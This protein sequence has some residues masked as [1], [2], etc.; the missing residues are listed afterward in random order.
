[1][2]ILFMCVAN[3]AR[4]QIAEGLANKIFANSAEIQSAGSAPSGRVHEDARLVM[5]E[6]G[7]DMSNHTSKSVSELSGAFLEG[8]DFVISLCAEEVCPVILTKANRLR[9]SLPDPAGTDKSA[10][11]RILAFRAVRD[12]INKRLIEFKEEVLG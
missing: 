1:M 5:S 12:E 11:E 2:K 8:L 6:V 9:W 3:S 7:I 4:S 10:E